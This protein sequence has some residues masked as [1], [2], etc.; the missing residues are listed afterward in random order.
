MSGIITQ[1]NISIKRF[2][3][4]NYL[5]LMSWRLILSHCSG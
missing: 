3:S 2:I 4:G 1:D 5:L